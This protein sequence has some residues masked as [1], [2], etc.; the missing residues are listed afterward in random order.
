MRAYT[1]QREV[2][3]KWA[4]RHFR[5]LK[6]Y[7]ENEDSR[8]EGLACIFMRIAIQTLLSTPALLQ[9]KKEI[10]SELRDSF[11]TTQVCLFLLDHSDTPNEE[12]RLMHLYPAVWILNVI[13]EEHR[14]LLTKW[15]TRHFRSLKS[16]FDIQ[17]SR[18]EGLAFIFIKIAIQN[19]LCTP[20]LRQATSDILMELRDS[21]GGAQGIIYRLDH[22]D[23]PKDE[24]QWMNVHP[25]VWL[26][27]AFSE[28]GNK[29]IYDIF[30]RRNPPPHETDAV[31]LQ[32]L[33]FAK[34]MK[35]RNVFD[36]DAYLVV[37]VSVEET[38]VL[39]NGL[40]VESKPTLGSGVG[41]VGFNVVDL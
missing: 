28:A 24:Y 38:L 29:E 12:Y 14:Q 33:N 30:Q 27:D 17:H 6:T 21:F 16:Y 10:L 36:L 39:D 25:A 18:Q 22:S 19:L 2:L 13:S 32:K 31:L 37:V 1:E 5:S 26:L 3:T 34:Q 40:E 23:I 15:A 9:C 11:T 7:F 8:Q 4:S 35:N 20:T 41:D